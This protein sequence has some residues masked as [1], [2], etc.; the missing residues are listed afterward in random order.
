MPISAKSILLFCLFAPL[1]ACDQH[2]TSEY[3]GQRPPTDTLDPAGGVGLQSKDLVTATEQMTRDLLNEPELRNSP[4]KW[5]LVID[6]V[7]DRTTER[8]F[9]T[10]YQIFLERLRGSL[11]KYGKNNVALAENRAK[12]DELRGRELDAN[13]A[14]NVMPNQRR[15]PQYSMYAKAMDMPNRTTNY[16]LIQFTVTDLQTGMQVWTGQYEVKTSR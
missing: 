10:D 4:T 13:D 3:Y 15:L 5:V 9:N 12:L 7:E 16:Y 1:A 11:F 6:K 14:A 8:Y 2:R